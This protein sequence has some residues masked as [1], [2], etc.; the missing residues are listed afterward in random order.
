MS[1]EAK[2]DDVPQWAVDKLKGNKVDKTAAN[3]SVIGKD[4]QPAKKPKQQ[5][6][7]EIEQLKIELSDLRDA[8]VIIQTKEEKKTS[9]V[10]DCQ[11][12]PVKGVPVRGTVNM[13]GTFLRN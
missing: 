6:D 5:S 13:A 9:A 3:S 12:K 1:N 11:K 4:V 7:P 10:Y 2:N 8:L